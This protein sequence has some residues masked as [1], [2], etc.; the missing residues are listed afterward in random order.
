MKVSPFCLDGEI[1]EQAL[2]KSSLSFE[3][4]VNKGAKRLDRANCSPRIRPSLFDARRIIF[5]FSLAIS[6]KGHRKMQVWKP[7]T[8]RVT[9][10]V[11]PVPQTQ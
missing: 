9:R 5:V 11:S 3:C 7:E 8:W 2:P 10:H 6:P 1:G 4:Q